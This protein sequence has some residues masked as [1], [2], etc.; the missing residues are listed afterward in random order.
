MER[1][2]LIISNKVSH[3]EFTLIPVIFLMIVINCT[4]L[5]YTIP[6][7]LY[8]FGLLLLIMT[9]FFLFKTITVKHTFKGMIIGLFIMSLGIFN[10][11]RGDSEFMLLCLFSLY[12]SYI[13]WKVVVKLYLIAS[14]TSVLFIC[15]LSLLGILPV[16]TPG[17]FQFGFIN[18]NVIGF[19]ITMIII[20]IIVLSWKRVTACKVFLYAGVVLII[21]KLFNDSTSFIGLIILG[22]IYIL[23]TFLETNKTFIVFL[24]VIAL[25]LPILGTFLS[26][27]LAKSYGKTSFS[28]KIDDILSMRPQI[29]NF[30][31]NAFP[32]KILSQ[33][34]QIITDG[35]QTF[36][37][38]GAFDGGYIEGLIYH[39]WFSFL[40]IIFA[41]EY[42]I[43]K[44][45]QHN[46]YEL[47]SC[48]IAL[49]IIA[50]TEGTPFNGFQS[51]MI[52]MAF[53]SLYSDYQ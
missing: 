52:P 46:N 25:L 17:S 21:Y 4:N 12:I 44:L 43:V 39:G 29:W 51:F 41:L 48:F 11:V 33:S 16:G 23:F 47:I 9:T 37:G 53:A 49:L 30:F 8:I 35:T 5:T 45:F 38:G 7:K 20:E 3:Y 36:V 28:L 1:E 13:S 14:I 27:W 26:L 22:I 18:S 24:K 40:L 50:F 6:Y 15:V 32:P 42:L 2:N 10:G 31:L 34:I 19:I